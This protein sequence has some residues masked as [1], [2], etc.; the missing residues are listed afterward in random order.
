MSPVRRNDWASD[1]GTATRNCHANALMPR[2]KV[3]QLPHIVASHSD[4]G[5][6][7]LPTLRR[8]AP[9]HAIKYA[10]DVRPKNRANIS[11]VSCLDSVSVYKHKFI[12]SLCD[13]D[14]TAT[15]AEQRSTVKFCEVLRRSNARPL[16]Q[17]LHWLPVQQRIN[18]NLSIRG[19]NLQDQQHISARLGLYFS[20]HG[21]T[22]TNFCSHL[23]PSS[24]ENLRNFLAKQHNIVSMTIIQNR[25]L[26][27]SKSEITIIRQCYMLLESMHKIPQIQTDNCR[28]SCK[29]HIDGI[30]GNGNEKHHWSTFDFH[31]HGISTVINSHSRGNPPFIRYYPCGIITFP[32]R[33][34]RGKPA[35]TAVLPPP[36]LPC[37]S[38]Q[39]K[40]MWTSSTLVFCS[41]VV[42]HV[43]RKDGV[44]Q[45]CLT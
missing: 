38:N 1:Y 28:L 27:T 26:K 37:T 4:R 19:T 29:S 34:Y 10:S 9:A 16:L 42:Q 43:V 41:T 14:Y 31:C 24:S 22:G 18:Y 15:H 17:R 23:H 8:R 5:Y 40:W 33:G 3:V 20:R 11:F 32:V 35:V 12:Y 2:V 13:C 36:P 7:K 39:R 6:W 30:D 45:A 25:N 21:C 44:R